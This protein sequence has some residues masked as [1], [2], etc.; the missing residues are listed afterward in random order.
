MSY[1]YD[2]RIVLFFDRHVRIIMNMIFISGV[3]VEQWN[4]PAGLCLVRR[5]RRSVAT[6]RRSSTPWR[7]Y[8]STSRCSTL[9]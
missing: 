4:G 7:L 2:T 9:R 8:R 6:L 1:S 5:S 3:W